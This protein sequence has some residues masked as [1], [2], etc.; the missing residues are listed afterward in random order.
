M[1]R[2][3]SLED[4]GKEPT[5]TAAHPQRAHHLDAL[6]VSEFVVH[7]VLVLSFQAKTASSGCS[8]KGR[9]YSLI[10]IFVI[11]TSMSSIFFTPTQISR[12]T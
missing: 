12:Y 9:L 11:I 1:T 5:G 6:A 4:G 2:D 3:K 7:W 8:A 10:P